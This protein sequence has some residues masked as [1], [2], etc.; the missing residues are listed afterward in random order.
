MT[1][2][3]IAAA[4]I[5]IHFFFVLDVVT[6]LHDW[7]MRHAW[8]VAT[9]T[10]YYS[11]IT[12]SNRSFGF[13]APEVSGDWNLAMTMTDVHGRQRPF[14][15]ATPNGEMRVKLYSL[16]GHFTESDTAMDL[17]ARSWALRA[18]NENRDV[19]RVDVVV[20][21]NSIPSMQQWR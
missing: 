15:F 10:N 8:P 6:H 21:Q 19:R 16:L 4:A 1:R 17:F 2:R 9:L 20:T 3:R 18:I 14:S 7:T 13:F 5:A 11:A 12:F